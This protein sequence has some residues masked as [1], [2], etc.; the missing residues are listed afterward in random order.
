MFAQLRIFYKVVIQFIEHNIICVCIYNKNVDLPRFS[1][2]HNYLVEFIAF[3]LTWTF[4]YT[5][6]TWEAPPWYFLKL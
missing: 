5:L 2:G 1:T 6:S 4:L 3:M